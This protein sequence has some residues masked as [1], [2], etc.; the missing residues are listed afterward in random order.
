ME[1]LTANYHVHTWR[2][3]HAS[4]TDREYI[5][6]AIGAGIRELGFSDHVP[7]PARDGYV[8]GIRMGMEQAPEYVRTLRRLGEEY[9]DRIRI[10]IGF[11]AEY[12]REFFDEQMYRFRMLDCDYLIMGQHFLGSEETGPYMGSPTDDEGR[13]REYVDLVIEGMETGCF[14]YL[15]HPDIMNYRGLDSVYDW[16]MTR[17]CK[18]MREMDIPL[19]LNMNGMSDGRHYPAERF[20]KIAGEV[21]NQVILGLDAHCVEQVRKLSGY[22]GCM[23]LADKYNLHLIDRLDI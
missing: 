22:D 11:E 21:G 5:E 1:F 10:Y 9:R 13:I 8:S 17:L 19:E 7:F 15:A 6:A 23:R 20:W 3:K 2:C 18:A 4:G 12:I 14:L 16:E